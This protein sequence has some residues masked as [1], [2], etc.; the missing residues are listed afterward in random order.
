MEQFAHPVRPRG[1]AA[2]APERRREIARLGG[3]AAQARGLAHQWT[4]E[5]ARV[6]GEKGHASRRTAT[7]AKKGQ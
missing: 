6:A 4:S 5:E 7:H 1:L 3:Q 2:V